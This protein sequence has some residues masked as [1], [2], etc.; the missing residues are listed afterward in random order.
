[1]LAFVLLCT[2]APFP[3]S[4]TLGRWAPAR[5]GKR[6]LWFPQ[7]VQAAVAEDEM[8]TAKL[9]F[10]EIQAQY[11]RMLSYCKMRE[12]TLVKCIAEPPKKAKR[13][14]ILAWLKGNPLDRVFHSH[15]M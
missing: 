15:A 13:L 10:G 8:R 3:E 1:M 2:P 5:H 7:K 6:L 11:Y 9:G 12:S 14:E 4:Q